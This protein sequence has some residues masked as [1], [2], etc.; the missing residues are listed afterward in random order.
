MQLKAFFSGLFVLLLGSQ[1]F[2]QTSAP[3]FAPSP[4]IVREPYEEMPTPEPRGLE[5]FEKAQLVDVSQNDAIKAVI[6]A[7]L[8][9]FRHQDYSKAYYAYSSSDFQNTV[10]LE[11]FKI[12]VRKSPALYK[13][14]S[15]ILQSVSFAGVVATVKGTLKGN[16]NNDVQAEYQLIQ[17][18]GNW[19]I[20]KV[21]LFGAPMPSEKK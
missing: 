19:K 15:F 17:E 7:Q 11:T 9:A 6:L 21:E 5:G 18:N 14:H 13:N 12:F 20:R 8:D 16:N 3:A 2:A 1:A 4:L 10:P